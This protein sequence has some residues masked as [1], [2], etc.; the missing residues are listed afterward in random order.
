MEFI[1]L[2]LDLTPEKAC[3]LETESWIVSTLFGSHGAGS[4]GHWKR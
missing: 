4:E 2:N 3:N 1:E